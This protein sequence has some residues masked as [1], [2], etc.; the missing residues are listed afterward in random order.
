VRP[1]ATPSTWP[2]WLLAPA[3]SSQGFISPDLNVNG[4]IK[5]GYTIT[6]AAD[7]AAGVQQIGVAADTCNGSAANPMSSY[8]ADAQPVTAGGT[9][10]RNFATDT[11]GTI[12][13]G[14][15]C[16]D[17]EPDCGHR[18]PGRHGSVSR[19][20]GPWARA[21]EFGSG[22]LRHPALFFGP[23]LTSDPASATTRTVPMSTRACLAGADLRA[24]RFRRVGRRLPTCTIG[25]CTIPPT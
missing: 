2:T 13:A 17:R 12:L 18:R 3:G 21:S 20:F 5:S 9:G 23:S 7:A 14:F 11:R 1:A 24:R 10:T 6:L 15:D 22:V 4:V 25:F 8:W 16:R 19:T